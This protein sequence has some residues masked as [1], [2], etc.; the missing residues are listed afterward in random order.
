[1]GL[2]E[3]GWEQARTLAAYL[4]RLTLDALYSSPMQRARQ[5]LQPILQTS[6]LT[7]IF[8]EDLREVDFGDWT[9]L[10][11]EDVNGKLQMNPFAW[12]EYLD[13]AAIPNAECADA[14]R[15][16]VENSLNT[17]LSRTPSQTVAVVCH[18][19]VIRMMLSILLK[20]PLVQTAAFSVE[21]ASLSCVDHGSDK[22]S[23]RFLNLV[24]WRDL[25]SC[26]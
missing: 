17:I 12:L 26:P 23:L 22:V 15:S 14:W 18:G 24:P 19:G 3:Q 2:S 5:T 16:R 20:T 7:P 6:T 13:R 8:L 11:W 9:G 21:Y 1:M 10:S 25:P 4:R